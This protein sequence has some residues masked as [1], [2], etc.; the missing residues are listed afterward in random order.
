LKTASGIGI[1]CAAVLL[2]GAAPD[3]RDTGPDKIDVSGYAPD[4]QERYRVFALKCSKCHSLARPINARITGEEWKPY[5][6]KM[7][8]RPGS[9]INE[10]AGQVVYEFLKFYSTV[11]RSSAS[12]APDG[13]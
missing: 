5:V 7:I 13:G 10:E 11:G 9:G 12:G 8:R 6:K 1:V 4:M 3:P 2:L